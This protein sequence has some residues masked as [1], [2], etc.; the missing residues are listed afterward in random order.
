V[1]RPGRDLTLVANNIM[2]AR[3]LAVAERLAAD[4]LEVEV[5]DPRTL[6][7][8]DVDPIIASVCRTGRLLVVHEACQTGGWAG[9]VIAAVAGSRAFDYL[10]APARRLAGQDMPIPYNRGLE[11]A[12]VPQEDDIE[13]EIR[14]LVSGA[15]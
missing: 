10:E 11:R 9:E 13:R 15:Y 7:P 5:I 3:A 1:K 4:G 12:A 8:L 6:L 14:A 2:V